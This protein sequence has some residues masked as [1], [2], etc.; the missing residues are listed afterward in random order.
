MKVLSTEPTYGSKQ[1]KWMEVEYPTTPPR[2]YTQL[3]YII[4]WCECPICTGS[5]IWSC[6]LPDSKHYGYYCKDCNLIYI[7]R[8]I[9]D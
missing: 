3:N 5:D 7:G 2:L 6:K 9:D 4:Q 1:I 8:I